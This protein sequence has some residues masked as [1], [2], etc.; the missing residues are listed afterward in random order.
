MANGKIFVLLKK[1]LRK[2]SKTIEKLALTSKEQF[3][4]NFNMADCL[5]KIHIEALL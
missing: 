1:V 2:Q 4:S 5:I 3:S